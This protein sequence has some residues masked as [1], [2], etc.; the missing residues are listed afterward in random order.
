M[1]IKSFTF[2]DDYQ[3]EYIE[4]PYKLYEND[5]QWIPPRNSDQLDLFST[6]FPLYNQNGNRFKNFVFV[7]GAKVIGRVSAF[8]NSDLTDQRGCPVGCIGYFDCVDEYEV[9]ES[10]LSSAITWLKR[11]SRI[12][13]IWGPLNFDIWHGYRFMTKGFDREV[14]AGEPYNKTYYPEYFTRFGF[15]TRRRWQSIELN[16]DE[17]LK[18]VVKTGEDKIGYFKDQGYHFVPFQMK[19]F[20]GEFAKMY[21]IVI[22]TFS[23]FPGFTPISK[24]DFVNLFIP[25][26]QALHSDLITFLHDPNDKAV[27]FASI[28]LDVAGACRALKGQN[29]LSAKLKFIYKRRKVDRV[30]FYICGILPEERQKRIGAGIALFT[31]ALKKIEAL[32][33]RRIVFALMAEDNKSQNYV[34]HYG[35]EM[36][37]EYTL[38]E[39]LV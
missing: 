26:K 8:I 29:S 36:D 27:G 35:K 39:Y 11:D 10:L 22:R 21:D 7:D 38:Y 13:T 32:G 25:F 9:A 31:Y 28:F 16:V 24:V 30:I 12:K 3:K 15:T 17:I 14:F 2:G 33:Y 18:K 23:E 34:K 6:N 37:R 19:D 5:N 1:A 4:F 20:R